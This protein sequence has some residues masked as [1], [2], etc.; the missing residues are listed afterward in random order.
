[1]SRL[2]L[3]EVDDGATHTVIAEDAKQAI[4]IAVYHILL[5]NDSWETLEEKPDV[6]EIPLEKEYTL[7]LDGGSQKL[8]L[9]GHQWT[10][11][12]TKPQYLGC[13]EW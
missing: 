7:H 12:I 2:K 9:T 5:A 3:F 13:S 10:E 4:S 11:L 1:M 8:K 6:R